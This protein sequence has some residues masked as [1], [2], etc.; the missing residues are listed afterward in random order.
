MFLKIRSFFVDLFYGFLHAF[1]V[2]LV[3]F[4]IASYLVLCY[5]VL[6]AF[7]RIQW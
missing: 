2:F 6:D 1:A 7:F 3:L 5:W 4:L